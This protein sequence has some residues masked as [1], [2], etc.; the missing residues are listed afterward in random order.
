MGLS[1]LKKRPSAEKDC[2]FHSASVKALAH[3]PKADQ[4]IACFTYTNSTFGIENPYWY[5]LRAWGAFVVLLC[6]SGELPTTGI[7]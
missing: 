4:W 1:K 3:H 7:S 6:V 5:S 2:D